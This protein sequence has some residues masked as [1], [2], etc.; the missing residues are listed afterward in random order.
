MS[1]VTIS[2]KN[3]DEERALLG[4]LDRNIRILRLAFK[5]EAVS[6]G[7]QLTVS[8]EP[9]KIEAAAKAIHKALKMIR[10]DGAEAP[11]VA[12]VFQE[13]GGENPNGA[14]AQ[15]TGKTVSGVKPRSPNQKRYMEA[16]EETPVTFGIG[17][18][19]TGKT[20]LA[21]AMAV[22]MV[23][24]GLYRKIIL[25]RPAVEAGEHLGFL[26]GDLE[27]KIM[28]YL[29]PLYDALE[30][31][32]SPS[33]LRR[34]MEERIV[35]I[36]PLAYM[37]GRTLNHAVIIL[38]EAQNTTIAQMKMFLTRMGRESKIIVTGD[39]SQVDLPGGQKSGLIHA[40]GVLRGVEGIA[41]RRLGHADIVR[42]EV[43]AAIVR[44]YG[45]EELR[46]REPREPDEEPDEERERGGGKRRR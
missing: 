7:G 10:E 5:V 13:A 22:S 21:V 1:E 34:F 12:D 2:L 24:A 31:L 36:S 33:T 11:E 39:A 23:K 17:P 37:R 32:L 4:H 38:D 46:D 29:R 14:R 28:P 44:A 18:A 15:R 26:P 35:E 6:R 25:V 43:V 30:D 20:Y 16:I 3:I 41:F 9:D 40:M 8:G 19:G 27:A 42:H 45:K